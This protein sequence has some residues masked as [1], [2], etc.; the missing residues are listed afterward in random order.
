MHGA[1]TSFDFAGSVQDSTLDA[2]FDAG[3]RV[4]V[5]RL[6]SLG[7][8]FR[9]GRVEQ[10]GKADASEET[11]YEGKEVLTSCLIAMRMIVSLHCHVCLVTDWPGWKPCSHPPYLPFCSPTYLDVSI[12][13][14]FTVT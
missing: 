14:Y 1:S 8:A 4:I 10:D 13:T 7:R 9:C 6:G 11:T 2:P 5:S 3:S 12:F